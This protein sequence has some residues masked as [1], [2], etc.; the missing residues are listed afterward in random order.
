MAGDLVASGVDFEDGLDA[1][2]GL[3]ALPEDPPA[4]PPTIQLPSF[5]SFGARGKNSGGGGSGQV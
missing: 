5:L 4:A 3:D 2:E 1:F